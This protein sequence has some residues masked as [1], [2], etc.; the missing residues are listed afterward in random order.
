MRSKMMQWESDPLFSAAEIVQES[1]DRME[2]TFRLLLHERSLVQRDHT[3]TRVLSSI[4]HNQRDLTTALETAK[5]QLEDFEREVNLSALRDDS[6]RRQNAITRHKQFI[7]AIREQIIYVEQSLENTSVRKSLTN[8]NLNEQD[9]NGLALFL[10]GGKPVEHISTHDSKDN[11]SRF[12]DP[13]ASSSSN[14]N[15]SER[16][17][18]ETANL[19]MNMFAHL[20]HDLNLKGDKLRKVGSLHSTEMGFEPSSSIQNAANGSYNV[21]GSWDLEAN[22]AKDKNH[23]PRSKLRGCCW[24]MS[25]L[26]SLGNLF[27]I[28]GSRASRSFAKRLKDGEEQMHSPR[29]PEMQRHLRRLL[30]TCGCS[31]FHLP[32]PELSARVMHFCSRIR[33]YIERCQIPL[34]RIQVS[35]HSILLISAML[36]IIIVLGLLLSQVA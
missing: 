3:D 33:T 18:G 20:N 15:I 7:E 35:R 13:A 30:S 14:D 32:C 10:S 29:S 11:T 12:F 25:I 24:I 36:L 6:Q 31:G 22:E 21:N 26:G 16:K 19:N 17:A 8:M 23:F 5:W 2:S 27:S 4:E 34:R 28:Y 1:A 9:R